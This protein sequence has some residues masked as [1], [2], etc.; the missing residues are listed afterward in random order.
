MKYFDPN[1]K[2]T[3]EGRL[4]KRGLIRHSDE[5]VQKIL[6]VLRPEEADIKAP[7]N[8]L[9]NQINSIIS[10]ETDLT[11]TTVARVKEIHDL[12]LNSR[13]K[14]LSTHSEAS[15]SSKIAGN[16]LVNNLNKDLIEQSG[17][18]VVDAVMSGLRREAKLSIIDYL[19]KDDDLIGALAA[20]YT[21]SKVKYDDV[22][23]NKLKDPSDK[24]SDVSGYSYSK[25]QD[26][27][28][29]IVATALFSRMGST[30]EPAFLNEPDNIKRPFFNSVKDPSISR[31]QN[32]TRLHMIRG[33]FG[34]PSKSENMVLGTSKSNNF[35][36]ESHYALTESK[37]EAALEW[38]NKTKKSQKDIKEYEVRYKV[39]AKYGNLPAHVDKSLNK[40]YSDQAVIRPWWEKAAPES[41]ETKWVLEM[42]YDDS[43]KNTVYGDRQEISLSVQ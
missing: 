31:K 36:D 34:G 22:E 28:A 35:H 19:E 29:G 2:Y 27:G 11:G 20:P 17:D 37:I 25:Q 12:Y 6:F 8:K 39:A 7:Y 42:K 3:V 33:R 1:S 21:V 16:V 23:I 40:K 32:L 41:I 13:D 30:S 4:R 43:K 18:Q 38:A 9:T 10:G 15:K 24:L 5:G 14:V 26:T